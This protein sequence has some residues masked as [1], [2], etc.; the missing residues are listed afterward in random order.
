[1]FPPSF[2]LVVVIKLVLFR[3]NQSRHSFDQSLVPVYLSVVFSVGVR[4]LIHLLVNG[5]SLL[6]YSDD[7]DTFSGT[8]KPGPM[9]WTLNSL[10]AELRPFPFNPKVH[11]PFWPL[12]G[13]DIL[14]SGL[15]RQH[16]SGKGKA[17]RFPN[18]RLVNPNFSHRSGNT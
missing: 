16:Y 14:V 1:V 3:W 6:M 18:F 17:Q 13:V 7:T 10:L 8:P 2:F 4:L 9:G 11:G 12:V 5:T 15:S